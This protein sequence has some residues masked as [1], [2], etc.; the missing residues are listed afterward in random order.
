[1]RM[2]QLKVRV[3]PDSNVDSENRL[4]N[5]NLQT[6]CN[7]VTKSDASASPCKKTSFASKNLSYYLPM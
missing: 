3:R 4:L 7:T 2:V 6:I 1:M 5:F